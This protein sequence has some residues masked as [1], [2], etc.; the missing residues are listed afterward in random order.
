TV[1][2][3]GYTDFPVG[4]G[5]MLENSLLCR[6]MYDPWHI[7]DT[8]TC[9]RYNLNMA[10][11]AGKVLYQNYIDSIRQATITGYIVHLEA[12]VSEELWMRSRDM[13]YH[14]T[15]YY[16]DRAGN[17]TRVVPPAG[18]NRLDITYVDTVNSDRKN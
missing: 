3:H 10:I 17:L 13:K 1:F 11:D 14:F 18:V 12:N 6:S 8:M 5:K 4:T 2:A 15:L 9:E 7:L 16:Y